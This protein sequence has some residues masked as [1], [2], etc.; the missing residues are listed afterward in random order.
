MEGE[1]VNVPARTLRDWKQKYLNA[2]KKYG[3][4]YIGLIPANPCK[5]II[6][7]PSQ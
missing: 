1:F 7:K 2:Q 6:H 4:G 5:H 3:K